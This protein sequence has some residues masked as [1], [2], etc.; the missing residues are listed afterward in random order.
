MGGGGRS[1]KKKFLHGKLSEKKIHARRV[2]QQYTTSWQK[3][4]SFK[5]NIKQKKFMLPKIPPV[6]R[7]FSNGPS[8]T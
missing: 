4:Y 6:P 1:T 2:D 8:L 5:G 7:N 3:K